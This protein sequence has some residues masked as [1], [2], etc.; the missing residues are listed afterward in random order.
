[1]P[2]DPL[3]CHVLHAGVLASYMNVHMYTFHST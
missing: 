2:L 3:D 1:M